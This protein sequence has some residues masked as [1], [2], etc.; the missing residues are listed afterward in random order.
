MNCEGI[1]VG[2]CGDGCRGGTSWSVAGGGVGCEA[3]CGGGDVVIG[4]GEK[5]SPGTEAEADG[6]EAGAAAGG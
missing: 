2:I 3:A 6:S 5:G 4:D 1:L